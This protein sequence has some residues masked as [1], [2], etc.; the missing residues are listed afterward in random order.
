MPKQYYISFKLVKSRIKNIRHFKQGASRCKMA[1]AGF[2]SIAKLRAQ[3]HNAVLAYPG[4]FQA[5]CHR[6]NCRSADCYIPRTEFESGMPNAW[7][8]SRVRIR[9]ESGGWQSAERLRAD[10]QAV[11]LIVAIRGVRSRSLAIHWNPAP[12][13][14]HQETACLKCR[15]YLK[16]DYTSLKLIRGAMFRPK[17]YTNGLSWHT[18][19]W[20]YTFK[21]PT[22]VQDNKLSYE[23]FCYMMNR[24]KSTDSKSDKHSSKDDLT[25]QKFTNNPLRFIFADQ[26]YLDAVRGCVELTN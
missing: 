3:F 9:P 22:I 15:I 14:L 17:L 5:D 18:I 7:T 19:S 16:R 21:V 4:V 26:W 2:H 8:A 12:A 1:R 10:C 20:Y 13:I 6:E 25:G 11:I 24:R 23:E